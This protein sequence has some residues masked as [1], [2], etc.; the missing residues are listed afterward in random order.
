M[1]KI[2]I[3]QCYR[4]ATL[5]RGIGGILNTLLKIPIIFCHWL[6]EIYKKKK[7]EVRCILFQITQICF[8]E[9]D[10]ATLH[11]LMRIM[12]EN[13]AKMMQKLPQ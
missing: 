10:Y 9:S 7:E 12:T 1:S 6:S 5:Y 11:S 4:F 2:W 13:G 8:N 3:K